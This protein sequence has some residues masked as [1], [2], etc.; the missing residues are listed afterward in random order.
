[1]RH[2][3]SIHA[4]DRSLKMEGHTVRFVKVADEGSQLR[5]K[6]FLHR[7]PARSNY[8]HGHSSRAKR[9]RNLKSDK[10]GTDDNNLL[11]R[12]DPRHNRLAVRERPQVEH[13]G[14]SRSLNRELHRIR[15]GCQQERA[16]FVRFAI[17]G[18]DPLLCGIQFRDAGVEKQVDLSLGVPF[19]RTQRNPFRRG[20]AGEKVFREV[21]TVARRRTVGA[22]HRQR[23]LV[24]F[25]AKHVGCGQASS[26]TTHD[27]DRTR[28]TRGYWLRTLL[29]DLF[30]DEDL[31][32]DLLDLPALNWIECRGAQGLT[33]P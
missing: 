12:C 24:S 8:M 32:A 13:L 1:Q 26:T 31:L 7:E 11:R 10:A 22:D 25:A 33:G 21:R 16:I 17:I 28:M 9:R 20:G 6:D 15:T 30:P 19:R 3:A 14:G 23:A 27:Y 4:T 5:T 29:C 2:S 18:S